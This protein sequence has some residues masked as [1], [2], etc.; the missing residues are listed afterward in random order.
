[1]P[2]DAFSHVRTWVFDLDN[3]LYPPS[4]RLFDQIE[5]LM[6]DYIVRHVGVSA[7]EAG[8]LRRLYWREHGTTLAGLMVHHGT[9]AD[10]FLDAVHRIDLSA[11]SPDPGLK[12]RIAALPG[13]KVVYTN[14]SRQHGRQVTRARGLEGAFDV[15]YGVEDAGYVPKPRAEAFAKVF[16]AEGLEPTAS[17]MFEDED[18][19]LRVPHALGLRT[20]LVGAPVEAVHVHHATDDLNG[21]LGRIG[22]DCDDGALGG[23]RRRA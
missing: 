15:I 8:A 16:G 18:R 21:F 7:A 11:L 22:P 12:A 1:M 4:A 10:D 17:A 23:T 19:N 20:V 2:R 6:T 13:R 9:D 3:T 5:R 14:G